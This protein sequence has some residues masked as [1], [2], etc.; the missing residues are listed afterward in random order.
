MM[1]RFQTI[2]REIALLGF[3]PDHQDYLHYPF[4]KR[5]LGAHLICS[6]NIISVCIFAVHVADSPKEYMDSLYI[7]TA[8]VAISVSYTT[9]A[10][11]TTK[12]FTVFS[13]I[14]KGIAERK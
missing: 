14:E 12:L 4:T 1:E 7:I 8:T 11:K 2:R 10:F 13:D 6:L 9:I 3:I 5:H